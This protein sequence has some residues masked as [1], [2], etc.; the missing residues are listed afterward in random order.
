MPRLWIMTDFLQQTRDAN[1]DFL[2]FK[3]GLSFL[4]EL[5]RIRTKRPLS[6]YVN[7]AEVKS[8]IEDKLVGFGYKPDAIDIHIL[9]KDP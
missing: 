9:T 1:G 8:E 5:C 4:E 6:V 7:S 2:P 3:G